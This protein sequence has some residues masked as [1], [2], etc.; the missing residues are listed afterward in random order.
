MP[1]ASERLAWRRQHPQLSS[2]RIQLPRTD[3]LQV[4]LQVTSLLAHII[5]VGTA[6]AAG[7]QHDPLVLEIPESCER[8]PHWQHG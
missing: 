6:A 2:I 3:M 7:R 4:D 5:T 8:T 1:L